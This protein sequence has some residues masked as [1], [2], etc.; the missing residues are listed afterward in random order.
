MNLPEDFR[1]FIELL[2]AQKV[3]YLIVGGY[4]VGFHSR[5]KFTNDLD[6]WVDNSPEN[7][8]K[9]LNVLKVFG[10]EELDIRIEDLTS[11]DH[12]IQLGYAPLRIDIMMSVSGLNFNEAYQNRVKGKYLGVEA[13]FA[14]IDDI[15]QNKKSSGRTKDLEDINWIRKY[16]K[17]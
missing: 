3:K 9:V 1:E 13:H 8:E 7:A 15:L 14:S 2:N 11:P 16:H 10:F 17:K 4:A 12:V 5:P 6:I